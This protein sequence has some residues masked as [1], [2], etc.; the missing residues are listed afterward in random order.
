MAKVRKSDAISKPEFHIRLREW[1]RDTHDAIVGAT[2][3]P[4][5]T[6][7]IYIQEHGNQYRLHAD[8]EREALQQYLDLV[9]IHGDSTEWTIVMNERGNMNAVAFGPKMERVTSFYLYVV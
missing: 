4:G 8:A 2:D 1:F 9:D 5:V 3:I 7:W 6:P